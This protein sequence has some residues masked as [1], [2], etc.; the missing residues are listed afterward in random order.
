LPNV[1]LEAMASGSAVVTTWLPEIGELVRDGD[2]GVVVHDDDELVAALRRLTLDPAFRTRLAA[3]GRATI[4]GYF[5]AVRSNAPLVELLGQHVPET[6]E[7]A[8]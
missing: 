3:N 1:L 5:D 2:N 6:L 7:V 4:A 8:A